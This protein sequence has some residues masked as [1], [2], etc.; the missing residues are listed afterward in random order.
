MKGV[1]VLDMEYGHPSSR[2]AVLRLDT[3]LAVARKKG[4]RVLKII[5]GYG[6][7]GKGGKLRASLRTALMR[8]KEPGIGR[9][10]AGESWSIFDA[11]SVSG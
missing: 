3:E 2:E 7:S 5:H 1:E 4:V 6:S 10:V 8:Q 11:D 9:V